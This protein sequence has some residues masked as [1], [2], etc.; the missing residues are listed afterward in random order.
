MGIYIAIE[1]G[2]KGNENVELK[3]FNNEFR[4]AKKISLSWK[5]VNH[6]SLISDIIL[7]VLCTHLLRQNK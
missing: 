7:T 5:E 4:D 2:D 1:P 6:A 3:M